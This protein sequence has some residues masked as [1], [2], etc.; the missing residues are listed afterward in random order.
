MAPPR[1]GST[2]A[3][4]R[5][6]HDLEEAALDEWEPIDDDVLRLVFTAC[7]PVLGQRGPG[8]AHAARR[9]RPHHRGDRPVAP[10]AGGDRAAADRAGEEDAR[11][12]RR[13]RS[14]HP[15]RASGRRAS[16]PCSAWSTSSSP[17]GTPRRRATGG[18]GPSSPNE[19]LRLGRVLAGLLPREPEVHGLVALMEFQASR[20][21]ARTGR[22]GTPILLAD[23]DRSR[24][25]HA[26]IRR[27]SAAL[28]RADALG[29][30]AGA[31]RLQAAI[32]ECHATAPSVDDTD[33]DTHRGALRGARSARPEP[34]R[35][36]QPCGRGVDGARARRRRC[37]SSTRLAA[38]GALRGSHLLPSVRG[39]LLTRLG[40]GR[41]GALGAADRREPGAQR[42]SA[43]G[44][45]GQGSGAVGTGP[46]LDRTGSPS[47][48]CPGGWT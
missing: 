13:C 16:A 10:R 38:A 21:A 42:P 23:Q 6:A 19:A 18:S 20:F 46:V 24:W 36:A 14:R 12:R 25:D 30:G 27:G 40:A 3:T 43:Q 1:I 22:D 33:W 47:V 5:I 37:R 34:R 11:R 17:R 28:A 32:A 8:R 48:G 45:D 9:R 39:E 7:H 44:V 29:R 15:S 41:G 26:Q 4:A 31:T 35:R 2:S